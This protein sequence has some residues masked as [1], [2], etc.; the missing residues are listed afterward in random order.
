MLTQLPGLIDAHVHLRTPG[1]AH[2]EDLDTGTRAALAGG[3][4]RVLDM[5]NT[6]PPTV[7]REALNA[8]HALVH[9]HAHCDVDLFGG[10]TE[11]NVKSV[12]RLAQP[13]PQGARAVGL[14]LYLNQT[15]GPL[16]LARFEAVLAH[17]RRWP[18]VV[19][20]H[21]EGWQ[22]AAAI[23]LAHFLGKHVHCCH[24]SRKAEI[25]LIR[26]AKERGAPVSC[27]VT[28]HH[29][30]LC[31]ADAER[32]GPLG[33]MK[34]TLGSAADRDALWEHLGVVDCIASDHA[35]HTLQEKQANPPAP[36][37]PG[38]E[39]TLPLMLTAVHEGRLS[40]ARLIELLYDGPRRVYS[41]P[42]QPETYIQVDLT[43]RHTL[44]NKELETKC[45]W[46]PFAGQAATGR[47]QSVTLYGKR[48]Y[49]RG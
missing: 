30:F 44:S 25:E 33:F 28:P 9:A 12:A 19:A 37:V 7:D 6:T 24:I 35:P 15:H 16:L 4:T 39:T 36:G 27:E 43:E 38:L 32:L 21:A 41:L 22:L 1:Q 18:G 26:A 29:L 14:K 34:P 48:V 42:A 47:L 2:K 11:G 10:G 23:G 45:G 3:F 13:G 49:D 20:V 8:K 46:T 31:E 5:P 40:L 17:V